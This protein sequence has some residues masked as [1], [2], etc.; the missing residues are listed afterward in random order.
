MRTPETTRLI[1]RSYLLENVLQGNFSISDE[2]VNVATSAMGPFSSPA[3]IAE[4]IRADLY[5]ESATGY[6]KWRVLCSKRFRNRA[7]DGAQS[8]VVLKKLEYVPMTYWKGWTDVKEN[9]KSFREL[10]LGCFSETNQ[11]QLTK[12]ESPIAIYRARLLGNVR[13]VVSRYLK[14]RDLA[15]LMPPPVLC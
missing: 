4:P 14:N 1:R 12:K 13:L 3:A 9:V 10:S 5:F 2:N 7:R 8:E 15:T 11:K 6:G